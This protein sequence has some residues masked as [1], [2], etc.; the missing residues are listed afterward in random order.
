MQ[1]ALQKAKHPVMEAILQRHHEMEREPED[2]WSE[3]TE[4]RLRKFIGAQPEAMG[5]ETLVSCRATQ[6]L[7]QM[8]DPPEDSSRSPQQISRPDTIM[9]RMQQEWWLQQTLQHLYTQH[10][11]IQNR[12]YMISIFERVP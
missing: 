8:S 12:R 2:A 6:C 10:V 7:I 5:I 9:L 3:D 1:Q 11:Q 4:T